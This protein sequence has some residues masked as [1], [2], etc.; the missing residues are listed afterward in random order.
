M[1]LESPSLSDVQPRL[2]TDPLRLQALERSGLLDTL[3][4]RAF[5]RLTELA[6]RLLHVPIA[7]VSL[8]DADRQFFKSSQGL[9]EPV[10]TQ[11]ET[12]LTHSFCQHVVAQSEPLIIS[13]ARNHPLVYNNPAILEMEVI[14]YLG[15][16]IFSPDQQVLGSFCA[17][18][19]QPHPWSAEA[20]ELM[21]EL[22]AVVM[23]EIALR[24]YARER[25]DALSA[26]QANQGQLQLALDGG[27]WGIWSCDFAS[28]QVDYDAQAR[29]ILGLPAAASNTVAELFATA[30]PADRPLI[31][32]KRAAALAVHGTYDLEF[33]VQ[34]A[35]RDIRWVQ[36]RGRPF[37]T[38]A[39]EPWRLAG[40]VMDITERKAAEALTAVE[41]SVS[42]ILAKQATFEPAAQPLLAAFCQVLHLEVGE[43]WM[44]NVADQELQ[45]TAS[46][47]D[48]LSAAA[49]ALIQA[50]DGLCLRRG[51]GLPGRAWQQ[52]A[53][54]WM[55]PE[56]NVAAFAGE[57]EEFTREFIQVARAERLGLGYGFAFPILHGE[58]CFGVMSFFTSHPVQPDQPLRAMLMAVGQLIGQFVLRTQVEAQLREQEARLQ[59]ALQAAQIGIWEVAFPSD[60]VTRSPNF[61]SIF[62]YPADNTPRTIQEYLARVHPADGER[63]AAAIH[64]TVAGDDE[65]RIEYRILLPDGTMRWV[66]MRG[67]VRHDETGRLIA[68][69]GALVDSSRRKLAEAELQRGE[70]HLRNVLNSLFGFVGVMT[71]DGT[72][73]EVNRTALTWANLRAE[74]VLGKPFAETYWWSYSQ[75]V[76][77]QMQ[78]AIAQALAGSTVRYDATVRLGAHRYI[79]LDFM[80]SPIFDEAG[81]VTYLVPSG[82][83]ITQRK[84]MEQALS[85]SEERFRNTFEQA[86]VGIAH[87]TVDGSWL[88]V[89]QRLCDMLG[90]SEEELLQTTIHQLTHPD[91]LA[92]ELAQLQRLVADAI[93]GYQLEKRY[94]HRD[95]AVIWVN[96][97]LSPVYTAS[98]EINYCIAVIEDISSRKAAE[99]ALRQFNEKLEVRVAERTAE[100]Q[101]RN[102]ELDQ[103]AYIASHDLKAPLRAI[104]NL[105]NWI[106]EDAHDRLPPASQEHL[107][108]LSGRVA[109]MER[110]L[111]DLLLY[112]RAGRQ[113]TTPELVDTGKLVRGI[114][115]LIAP[116]TFQ[117]T[118]AAHMP[119]VCV[120]R[121][122]LE[123]TLR[124]LISNAI[125]HHD[126]PEVG[127]I[128]VAVQE[129]AP[130]I[131]FVITDNGPGIDPRFHERIFTMFQTLQP[132]DQVEASGI[133]LAIVKKMV[134]SRGGKISIVSQPGAGAAFG[135]SWPTVSYGVD[136]AVPSNIG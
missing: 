99:A 54:M 89:N 38:A 17:I 100:L 128:T 101:E 4:E 45:R 48:P 129:E 115:E 64:N 26:L 14:A 1:R 86:A 20:V 31:D 95:G 96:L 39:G 59:L 97:T 103:F 9:A 32:Q 15:I 29:I 61:D 108:K 28:D 42:T 40:V 56:Q 91:D 79:V 36:V 6:R 24:I 109:R 127:H 13:D 68:L 70:Q 30:H 88:F 67:D 11:R 107:R 133:G 93:D 66:T 113:R 49:T 110:L 34:H 16:P 98:G 47:T 94:F 5:D 52:Q 73:I 121:V 8:V 92:T 83:D 25:E 130:F 84:L 116:P 46:Y 12:P 27:Q 124:N 7:L 80:L 78:N 117:V 23:D 76:Q 2:H 22:A 65:Y 105:A 120:E 41:H 37:Y 126:H 114:V 21:Q 33:R 58:Q 55:A 72:L 118:L 10:A 125:K 119:T 74:D 43:L 60:Q 44:P 3:P 18:D 69:Q 112:S 102:L 53:P 50:T 90:Y 131:K 75:V 77:A 62:G 106:T 134:E 135:F 63:L 136:C 82:I 111:D 57:P 122:P 104:D 51:Q 85:A 71:P 19:K 35:Q 81:N 123:T 87:M 132:R